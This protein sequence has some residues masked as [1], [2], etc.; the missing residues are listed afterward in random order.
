MICHG[1]TPL[2]KITTAVTQISLLMGR[3]SLYGPFSMISPYHPVPCH[4]GLEA[5]AR[6]VR[7]F[8]PT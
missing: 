6:A 2:K 3:G 5:I 4:F 7:P 1:T 8:G